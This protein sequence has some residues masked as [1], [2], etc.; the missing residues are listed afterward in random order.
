M[1]IPTMAVVTLVA[2]VALSATSRPPAQPVLF[3]PAGNVGAYDLYVSDHLN[4]AWT[5]ARKLEALSSPTRDYSERGFADAPREHALTYDEVERSFHGI[6]NGLGNIYRVPIAAVHATHA[7]ACDA[8]E[9]HQ[10]DF[11]IG[12]WTVTAPNG[13]LAGTNT[14]DRPLGGCVLQEHWVGAR[15]SHGS[16]FNIYDATRK[17]WHQTWVDDQGTLL[18]LDGAYANGKM[19]L[20]GPGVNQTGAAIINRITWQREHGDPDRVRQ[21]W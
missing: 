1:P 5:P 21:L 3:A 9:Y 16:S 14:I 8:A 4:R 19:I 12:D 17:Q 15:G 6:M 18:L 2:L 20:S 7:A 13:Q 11:W 10:F